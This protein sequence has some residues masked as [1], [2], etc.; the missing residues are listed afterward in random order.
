MSLVVAAVYALHAERAN[1]IS[2]RG[3]TNIASLG[4]DGP[5]PMVKIALVISHWSKGNQHMELASNCAARVDL[6]VPSA[7]PAEVYGP[8][9]EAVSL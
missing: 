9:P 7:P 2:Y 3:P 1:T 8:I 5:R 4:L 6:Y